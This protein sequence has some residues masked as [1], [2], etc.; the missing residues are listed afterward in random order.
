M[1]ERLILLRKELGLSQREFGERIGLTR[2]AIASYEYGTAKP[3]SIALTA[4]EKEYGARREWLETGEGEMLKIGQR[5]RQI[6][7]EILETHE[8]DQTF[9]AIVDAYLRLGDRDRKAIRRYID[10][11]SQSIAEGES[12]VR[13]DPTQAKLE[14]R[15]VYPGDDLDSNAAGE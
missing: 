7:Q 12:P 14:S 4:I 11:L 1:R 5:E 9:R 6:S 10:M 13:V 15:V 3:T 2:A 8:N